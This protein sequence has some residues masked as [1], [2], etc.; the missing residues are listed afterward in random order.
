MDRGEGLQSPTG[1][2]H[3]A[4]FVRGQDA[5]ARL[6][7]PQRRDLET[8]ILR[9]EVPTDGSVEEFADEGKDPVGWIGAP[10]STILSSKA[11]TS[12]RVRS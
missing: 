5:I 9:D 10:R 2:P 7:F 11:S 4:E 6:F 8:G 1:V 12:R 3:G